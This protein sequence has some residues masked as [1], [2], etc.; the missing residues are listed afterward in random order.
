MNV[1]MLVVW[2]KV[3]CNF[4]DLENNAISDKCLFIPFNFNIVRSL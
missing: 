4:T 2:M 1:N 3:L